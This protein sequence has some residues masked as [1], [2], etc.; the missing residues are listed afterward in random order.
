MWVEFEVRGGAFPSVA[1]GG[2]GKLIDDLEAACEAEG[3]GGEVEGADLFVLPVHIDDND[4]A[5]GLFEVLL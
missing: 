3:L 5:V 4:K 1:L 2:F